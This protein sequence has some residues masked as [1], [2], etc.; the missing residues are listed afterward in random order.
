MHCHSTQNFVWLNCHLLIILFTFVTAFATI[1]KLL[2]ER[3]EAG[4]SKLRDILAASRL[5]T[6]CLDGWT[7]KA[8]FLGISACSFQS[9]I[10]QTTARFAQP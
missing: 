5:V 4:V 9:Y 10:R 8:S 2:K 1:N 7:T 6:I 3:M